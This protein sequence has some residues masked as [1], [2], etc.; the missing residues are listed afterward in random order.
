MRFY[1]ENTRFQRKRVAK[2]MLPLST[3]TPVEKKQTPGSSKTHFGGDESDH[4]TSDSGYT[5]GVLTNMT[6]V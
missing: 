6:P 3:D 1:K 2:K 4:T 5:G